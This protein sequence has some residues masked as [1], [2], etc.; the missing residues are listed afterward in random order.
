MSGTG[1]KVSFFNPQNELETE[2]DESV[3]SFLQRRFGPETARLASAMMHGI[4]AASSTSLSARAIMGSVYE[5]ER[6]YGSVILGLLRR[7]LEGGVKRE[8]RR[9]EEEWKEL[10]ELGKIREGWSMYGLKSGIGGLTRR[11]GEEVAKRGEV[12]MGE[13]VLGVRAVEDGVE[14]SLLL[15]L[16]ITARI[17]S[18]CF[19]PLF[20]WLLAAVELCAIA[21]SSL[22]AENEWRNP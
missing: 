16:L 1:E 3:D 20:R 4:Y 21:A 11:L 12:R 15:W 10:G 13:R 2:Q 9:L 22:P 19:S 6:R 17:P 18:T 5:G 7:G 14:V 8:K